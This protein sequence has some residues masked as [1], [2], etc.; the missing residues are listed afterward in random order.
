MLGSL[1]V[2][3]SAGDAVCLSGLWARFFPRAGF[4]IVT[5]SPAFCRGDL[6]DCP[7]Q[8]VTGCKVRKNFIDNPHSCGGIRRQRANHG[9]CPR[10]FETITSKDQARRRS[11]GAGA[12]LHHRN[13]G[14]FWVFFHHVRSTAFKAFDEVGKAVNW[15]DVDV[16]RDPLVAPPKTSVNP[17]LSVLFSE[18]TN[19]DG[20]TKLLWQGHAKMRDIFLTAEVGP[21]IRDEKQMLN[22]LPINVKS[23][24][25]LAKNS[26]DHHAS[27][28]RVMVQ[29][30]CA[31]QE[32]ELLLASI[33]PA[34]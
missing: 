26:V 29:N 12:E 23:C 3:E 31:H 11:L 16:F 8:S 21:T 18:P 28:L 25:K 6:L 10:H 32:E 33:S 34:R 1:L 15:R 9:I 27:D 17:R 30:V 20:E 19:F 4:V 24:A 13:G 5:N 14:S 22:G 7:R 2:S